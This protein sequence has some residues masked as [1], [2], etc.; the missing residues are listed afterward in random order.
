MPGGAAAPPA[1]AGGTLYVVT[2]S[3]TLVAYR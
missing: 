1:I 3:G 2:R